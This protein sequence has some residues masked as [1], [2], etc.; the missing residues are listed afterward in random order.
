MREVVDQ[1]V[2]SYKK[3]FEYDILAIKDAGYDDVFLW[4]PRPN[5]T[6]LAKLVFEGEAQ[7]AREYV[8][9]VQKVMAPPLWYL[10]TRHRIDAVT[11]KEAMELAGKYAGKAAMA[12]RMAA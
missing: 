6:Q 11:P 8:E 2:T 5:G 4:A 12:A 9:A 7:D 1:I 3:D 10:V